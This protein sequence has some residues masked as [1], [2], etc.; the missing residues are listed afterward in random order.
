MSRNGNF[1]VSVLMTMTL[2]LTMSC[3]PS[4]KIEKEEEESIKQYLRDNNITATP[5]AS[6]LYYI[7]NTEGTGA[8]P[9]ANDSVVVNYI[10]AFLNGTVFDSNIN[11]KP[12]VFAMG[13]GAVISGFEEGISYMKKGGKATLLL[14]SRLAYGTYGD[15]YGGIPGY[16]PIIFRVELLNIKRG[17][18]K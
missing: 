17:A 6:G 3:D 4:R 9:V 5:T 14:P 10:G 11:T 1:L 15:Y 16:T 18:G 7:V 8:Y 2:I 13:T 12:I